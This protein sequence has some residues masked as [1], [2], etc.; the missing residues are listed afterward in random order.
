MKRSNFLANTAIASLLCITGLSGCSGFLPLSSLKSPVRLGAK[1]ISPEQL[2][3]PAS[4]EAPV[5]AKGAIS[6]LSILRTE[7]GRYVA[8]ANPDRP[9][10]IMQLTDLHF[11]FN[12]FH[13]V[14]QDRSFETNQKTK[15]MV[16]SCV[17]R[18]HPDLVIVTGDLVW[19]LLNP[20]GTSAYMKDASAFL[21]SLCL[22]QNCYWAY[23]F[24]NHE[25]G[26][27]QSAFTD[28]DDLSADLLKYRIDQPNGRLLYEYLPN[29][30]S[31]SRWGMY[32]LEF[33][34]ENG[35]RPLWE[36][37]SLYSG[38][39]MQTSISQE[40]RSW[41]KKNHGEAKNRNEGQEVPGFA[42]FHIP[43]QQY[44]TGW[45]KYESHGWKKNPSN[46]QRESDEVMAAFQK[47]GVVATFA[48]HDHLN[49]FRTQW[50]L[51]SRN[52]YLYDG[53]VSGDGAPLI[54]DFPPG[55]ML[56]D[57]DLQGRRWT[58]WEWDTSVGNPRSLD[59]EKKGEG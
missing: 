53:R 3:D 46:G 19:T 52:I 50:P 55:C 32:S 26:G 33:V 12:S 30:S 18:F 49:N 59:A 43:L 38:D 47:S 4:D 24:G 54:G 11:N 27:Y 5:L 14:G 29:D 21:N 39:G 6:P 45:D 20:L 17:A 2:A 1:A 35:G 28:R 44:Q 36:C 42:F 9:I 58:A 22:S 48:G 25:G 57:V 7:G 16:S 31:K 41:L 8:K 15:Q 23:V 56:I 40:E 37:Y 34:D 51:G 10:R 13:G